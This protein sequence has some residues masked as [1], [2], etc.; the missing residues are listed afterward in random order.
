MSK[1]KPYERIYAWTTP[2]GERRWSAKPPKFVPLHETRYVEEYVHV[3]RLGIALEERDE[4][5][6][7]IRDGY[8]TAK[9]MTENPV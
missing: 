3:S 4:L 6:R 7:I 8:E 9:E 1:R 5:A 2:A